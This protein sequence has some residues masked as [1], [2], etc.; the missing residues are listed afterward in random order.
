VAEADEAGL[1]LLR[2]GAQVARLADPA[3]RVRPGVAPAV[4]VR[5]LR[6]RE[7]VLAVGPVVAA[8]DGVVVARLGG[9]LGAA[10]QPRH[11][12]LPRVA[13]VPH[14]DEDLVLL[15]GPWLAGVAPDRALHGVRRR[16]WGREPVR[17][18]A[19]PGAEGEGAAAAAAA[20]A[21]RG[22]GPVVAG[23]AG[24]RRGAAP[25]ARPALGRWLTLGRAAADRQVGQL[26]IRGREDARAK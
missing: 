23:G 17:Q 20:A 1:L 6:R 16:G 22:A 9:A 7:G 14:V 12:V 26:A 19:A 4:A 25:A 2:P 8:P 5:V 13:L 15:W 21:G 10:R 3:A 24:P 18:D 11:D